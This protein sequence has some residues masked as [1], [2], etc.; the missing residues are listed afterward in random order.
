[1]PPLKTYIFESPYS[2][3]EINVKTYGGKRDALIILGRIVMNPDEWK[4][5]Q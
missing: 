2:F 3:E 1:M 4:L 5:K